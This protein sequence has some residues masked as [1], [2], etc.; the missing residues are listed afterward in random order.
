MVEKG[1]I[2]RATDDWEAA[3][4]ASLPGGAGFNPGEPAAEFAARADVARYARCMHRGRR[5]TSRAPS[6]GHGA[7]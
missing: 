4:I 6:A 5:G 1:R 7:A 3:H 2:K